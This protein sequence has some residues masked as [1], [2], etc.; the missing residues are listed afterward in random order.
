MV[1]RRLR[2]SLL[3]LSRDRPLTRARH[4][5][6]RSLLPSSPRLN[7]ISRRARLRIR[8]MAQVVRI[9]YLLHL[10]HPPRPLLSRRRRFLVPSRLDYR[11][12]IL[13]PSQ[14]QTRIELAA[15]YPTLYTSRSVAAARRSLG[16]P[17]P[18][19]SMGMATTTALALAFTSLPEGGVSLLL[20]MPRLGMLAGRGETRGERRFRFQPPS[21]HPPTSPPTSNCLDLSRPASPVGPTRN[22]LDLTATVMDLDPSL[23]LLLVLRRS[24][25]NCLDLVVST[26]PR[27]PPTRVYLLPLHYLFRA[28]QACSH[29][30]QW[31]S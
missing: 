13:S 11:R 29:Q 19:W 18:S 4:L 17:V 30:Q 3:L 15:L 8:S 26:K 6:A 9:L 1:I 5:S 24:T 28:P 16:A 22:C 7:L 20:G 12:S 23:P 25:R 21:R 27:S 31:C 2:L 10:L 14:C